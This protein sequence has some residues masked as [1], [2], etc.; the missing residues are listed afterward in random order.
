MASTK[1]PF[2][3]HTITPYL[4]VSDVLRLIEFLETVFDATI[5]GSVRYR[6]DKSVQHAEVQIGDSVI[7]MGEPMDGIAANSVGLYTYVQDCDSVYQ[8]A[9]E[10]GATNVLEVAD[11]LHGDRYGGVK[12][13]AGNT[14]WIV[15]HLGTKN[16]Q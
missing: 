10:A 7:M 6:D 13:F 12:D 16:Q 2:G 3:L 9:L 11:Y 14:W 5:R 1:N 4:V 15:S 8:K